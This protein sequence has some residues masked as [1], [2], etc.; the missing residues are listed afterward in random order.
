MEDSVTTQ[1]CSSTADSRPENSR[2][3]PMRKIFTKT[4]LGQNFEIDSWGRPSMFSEA[5]QK[6]LKIT[7]L[8]NYLL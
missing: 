5:A 3:V 8:T 6:L 1:N 4:N 2:L 7:T